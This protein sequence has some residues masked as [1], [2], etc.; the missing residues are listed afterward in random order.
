MPGNLLNNSFYYIV[1]DP[2]EKDI[3]QIINILFQEAGLES[4]QE[5]FVQNFLVV[6]K[7]AKNGVGEF[8]LTLH[9]VRKYIS[10]RKEIP[11]LDKNLFM[12]FI[13]H[14]HFNRS[15]NKI[16]VKEA[17]KFDMFLFNPSIDY[18]KNNEYL[19]FQTSTKNEKNILKI[20][21]KNTGKIKKDKY[22]K[23]FNSITLNEKFCFLFLLCCVIAKK[24][25]IIQ[26]ETASGKSF[27]IKLFSKIVGQDLDIYQLNSNSGISLFTG[28]SVMKEEFEEKEEQK[29]KNILKLLNKEDKEIL[30]KKDFYKYFKKNFSD[31]QK[32]IKEKLEHS[33]EL[34][35]TKKK[36]YENAKDTLTILKSPLN[37]F[38]HQDSKLITGIKTGKW[39]ALDGIEMA[40]TQISEKLSSLCGE[41][42]TLS[43]FESGLEDLNFN[44]SNI[45][46]D[47]RLFI[48]Y[49]PLSQNSK[50]IDKEL[51]N[52]CV[53]FTLPSIDTFPRDATTILYGNIMNN[54]EKPTTLDIPLWSNLCARIARYHIEQTKKTKENTELVAGN[55]PFT[56]RNLCFI[57]KD[58]I[59][60]K[61]KEKEKEE[62]DKKK[63]VIESWLKS[64][65]ENYYWR[66]FI[67]Y[68]KEEKNNFMEE[69]L[70]IIKT[71]PDYQYK[72]DKELDFKQEFKEIILYLVKI[73]NYS[74]RNIE[75]IEFDFEDFLKQCI[76][77]VPINEGKMKYIYN[78]LEDTILLLDNDYNMKEILKNR[79][80]Q[81]HFIK[82]N[83][84]NILNYLKNEDA[85][86]NDFVKNNQKYLLSRMIFLNLI[87]KN[88][89][90]NKIYNPNLNYQL[91][92]NHSNELSKILLDL[93]KYKTKDYFEDLIKFLVKNPDAFKIIHYYYPYDN[94]ELKKGELKY[95]NY[96]IY[97]LYRLHNKKIN[98]SIRLENERY[99]FIFPDEDQDKK[100]N[101][102]FILNEENSLLLSKGTFL[103]NN[104]KN[105]NNRSE[106]EI[107]YLEKDPVK[108]TDNMFDWIRRNFND[109]YP[110]SPLKSLNEIDKFNLETPNFFKGNISSLFSRILSIVIN[111][112]DKYQPVIEY[113]KNACCFLEKDTI[114]IFESLYTN[115]DY[116]DLNGLINNIS[117]LSFF[118]ESNSKSM[119]W[120]Y[121]SLLKQEYKDN[122]YHDFFK[123]ENIDVDNELKLIENEI[124]NISK[125]KIEN[126]WKEEEIASYKGKL[127][128]LIN[129][130]NSYKYKD[131]EDPKILKLKS[132][133]NNLLISLEKNIK[134]KTYSISLSE[135][136]EEISK[137]IYSKAPTQELYNTL[138]NKVNIYIKSIGKKEQNNEILNLPNKEQIMRIID[139]SN[140]K[141]YELIFWF[142]FIEENLKELLGINTTEEDKI[143]LENN[144]SKYNELEP[145]MKFIHDRKLKLEKNQNFSAEDKESVQQMLRGILLYKMK[146]NKINLD[147]Y[148]KIVEDMNSKIN[149]TGE[150]PY[151]EYHFSYIISDEYPLN[152]KIKIPIFQTMDAFYLFYKYD[153]N[154]CYKL[155]D[156]FNGI[157]NFFGGIDRIA[158]EIIEKDYNRLN[159][160]DLSK[161]LVNKFYFQI[162]G[163]PLN[164]EGKINICE[165][166]KNES[167]KEE[168]NTKIILEKIAFGL[169]WIELFQEKIFCHQDKNNY[170]FK[171]D[172]LKNLL[173]EKNNLIDCTN[174]FKKEKKLKE[175]GKTK[176]LFS[177]SF[178]F[179]IN[180]KETF[181]NDL[182][183]NINKSRK[184]IIYDLNSKRK[185]YY[186]PFWLYI[187]RNITSLNCLEYSRKEI[188]KNLTDSIVD[189]VKKE[190]LSCLKNKIPLNYKWLNLILDN[191][192]SELLDHT[193]HLFYNFF[194]KLINYLNLPEQSLDMFAKDELREYFYAIID[195]VFNGSINELLNENINENKENIILKMTKNPSHYL[196]EKI[197]ADINNK[198][199]EIMSEEKI[200]NIITSFIN[201]FEESSGNFILK[202]K[203]V[204]EILFKDE[205]RKMK[206]EYNE[207]VNIKYNRLNELI[208]IY[209]NK[210]SAIFNKIIYKKESLN[211]DIIKKSEKIPLLQI[212]EE[213]F[214]VLKDLKYEISI[215]KKYGITENNDQKLICFKFDYD[216]TR[217]KDKKFS[218][219]IMNQPIQ[220]D[221]FL[222]KGEIYLITLIDDNTKEVIRINDF[223]IIPNEKKED[224]KDKGLKALPSN[225]K[226]DKN[227]DI[228][229]I[230]DFININTNKIFYFSKFIK[231]IDENIIKNKIKNDIK[232]PTE[233]D[234]KNPPEILLANNNVKQ[235]SNSVDKLKDFS[236]SLSK[237]FTEIK[238]K[239]I[240]D[241]LIIEKFE[242]EI[243]NSLKLLKDIKGMLKLTQNDLGLIELSKNLEKI[244][245]D[246][247]SNLDKY[248]EK[249]N[250]SM[251]EKMNKFFSLE[252]KK[253]FSLDFSLPDIPQE[254]IKSNIRLEDM[255]KDSKNLCVPV[256]NIDGEGKQLICCYKSLDLNLGQIC[257]AF[258]Y[259]PY[260]I[261]IIS[262]VNEDLTVKIKSYKLIN[263]IKKE[264]KKENKEKNQNEGEKEKKEGK[265]E[266]T[267]QE[268][269]TIINFEYNK[270]KEHKYLSVKEL[271]NKGE[272]IQLFVEVPQILDEE[273]TFQISSLLYIESSSKKNLELKVNI[274]LRTIPISVLLSCKEY[275][276]IK[277]DEKDEIR[278]GNSN[279]L[280]L[281]FKLDTQELFENEEINFN[282]L[283]YK[284][285]EPIEFFVS[286][287][288]LENNSSDKPKFSR[289]KEKNH[290]KII[291]P[292]YYDLNLNNN[293]ISRLHCRLEVFIN[294]NFVLYIIIDSLIRPNLNTFK[295]YD[296]YSKSYKE[297]EIIIYSNEN[298]QTIY[299]NEKRL[300]Q[301]NCLIFSLFENEEFTIIPE[302]FYGGHIQKHNGKILKGENQFSLFLKFSEK[303]NEFI[304]N[305]T[306]C[307]IN[308]YI[309]KEQLQ[310]K[311]ILYFKESGNYFVQEIFVFF[312]AFVPGH[313]PG[314]FKNAHKEINIT[315]L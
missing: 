271:V 127:N 54:I 32:Q 273:N 88:N 311:V 91:F 199:F 39:I 234:V 224:K 9:E 69:T 114:K 221:N 134:Y 301:L 28:Q 45:N 94:N 137:F 83:Y 74:I 303:E 227:V 264:E 19:N 193:I 65:F 238:D 190:I 33:K 98:F 77:K 296:F 241:N 111:L 304:Q 251:K 174:I 185:I 1:E 254:T 23:I 276:L 219:L 218:F 103:K 53:K 10:F 187:L 55:A 14:N 188:D 90:K 132:D 257:P 259:G 246:F 8:P 223:K 61:E 181:I 230:E 133:A 261:N 256:I 110:E 47:F 289:N 305:G 120:K 217:I 131:I 148:N 50:K 109:L 143:Q 84:E 298:I 262:F 239:K 73:Q 154:D 206:D 215:Y 34:S 162:S 209:S 272:N 150:I 171:L 44:P 106:Y 225:F 286:V 93:I 292:K 204:N 229:K 228:T 101:P 63:I 125:L 68:S 29:L 30:N 249:Y 128:D 141:I 202:I 293:E 2:T 121:R 64:I 96:Y 173:D 97:Y 201:K 192:S 22:L 240:N 284:E 252:G 3:K 189:K 26:G 18:D 275:K 67:N 278:L 183:N 140:Y 142:S 62:K 105:N 124:N 302:A 147:Y 244:I 308:I 153:K 220:I 203:E 167:K 253:I 280:I 7:I 176:F 179:Y 178:I 116:K 151:D 166:L 191:V 107:F 56:S 37:R 155:G 58:F 57:S 92:T 43:V 290:F 237:I 164:D 247:Y 207:N 12:Y 235:F 70:N 27:I 313:S 146:N 295:M 268:E 265:E 15:E 195:S 81:I 139:T 89:N 175:L 135:L 16:K 119:L 182:F 159:M 4:E 196:Y 25:P 194:N 59:Y 170:E 200:D 35:E 118:C 281:Y 248:Y 177:P 184:S 38:M 126:F 79:F 102:Y 123:S 11:C 165:F 100:I 279:K 226:A 78:N 46:P 31:I 130:I 48:I 314:I 283:N 82:N 49:N 208:K 287:K 216:F 214:K 86:Q 108:N 112:K 95:A 243:E 20:K 205:L 85:F 285:N 282:L 115:L 129:R 36:E 233:K 157:T 104:Y 51:F 66:S 291:I 71:I 180:N 5:E 294:N 113:L 198:F 266:K 231:P 315:Y 163:K 6:Q 138:K 21:I 24:T 169:E 41:A 211:F 288:S 269:K 136:K 122:K 299:K 267:P 277:K 168:N 210:I 145:I 158:K 242:K 255:K 245:S 17:L 312:F 160:I 80:Y 117:N 144:L 213:D 263:K 42:P 156:L 236:I 310:F 197:K 307:L 270:D 297:K 260:V 40:N 258:Y 250:L 300:I 76:E 161:D 222:Y 309:N 87:L 212:S 186:L 60:Q 152:L 232:I 274:I 13:F 172:D 149:Y 72:V 75:Y 52:K 99:D 306:E